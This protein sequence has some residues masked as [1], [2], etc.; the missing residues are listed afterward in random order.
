MLVSKVMPSAKFHITVDNEIIKQ[1]DSFVY[2]GQ[3]L[4]EDAKCDK[5]ILRR[6]SIDRGTFNE[7]KST[8]TNN[9]LNLETRKIILKCYVWSTLFYGVETGTVTTTLEKHL[10]AF[11]MWSCRKMLK[12]SWTEKVKMRKCFNE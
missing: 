12:L 1:E 8:L 11:E 10:E 3:L 5:E 2:L 4:T 9:H 7:M 6:I